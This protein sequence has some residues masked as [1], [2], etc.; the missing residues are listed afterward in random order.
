MTVSLH[1]LAHSLASIE[2]QIAVLTEQIEKRVA[3]D[4]RLRKLQQ[5]LP[6]MGRS[7]R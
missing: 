3:S 6:S 4:E 5:Q 1:V 2:A 7:R